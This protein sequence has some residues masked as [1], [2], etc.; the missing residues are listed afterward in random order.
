MKRQYRFF[1]MEAVAFDDE[2][3]VS[4]L[5][6][7]VLMQ[8]DRDVPMGLDSVTV[9]DAGQ[10]CVVTDTSQK[11]K[12][13]LEPLGNNGF[14]LAFCKQGKFFFAEG[15]W[16]HH[17]MELCPPQAVEDPVSVTLAFGNFKSSIVINQGVTLG[18]MFVFLRDMGYIT[19]AECRFLVGE[20]LCPPQKEY[21]ARTRD[22]ALSLREAIDGIWEPFLRIQRE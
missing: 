6:R 2:G 21:D 14:C 19:P 17:M 10:Y 8:S 16:G 22:G 12:N 3:T 15:G 20:R 13:V 1:D 7:H 4:E 9:Y 18:E 11:C 5:I